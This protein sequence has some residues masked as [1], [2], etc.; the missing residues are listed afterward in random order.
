MSIQGSQA[1]AVGRAGSPDAAHIRYGFMHL[2][3]PVAR[4]SFSS[5][6]IPGP[7]LLQPPTDEW[8]PLPDALLEPDQEEW[9]DPRRKATAAVEEHPDPQR[10]HEAAPCSEPVGPIHAESAT[11]PGAPATHEATAPVSDSEKPLDALLVEALGRGLAVGPGAPHPDR[12]RATV[13]LLLELDPRRPA[14]WFAV[15]A[16][17]GSGLAAP[18]WP[19]PLP[20]AGECREWQALGQLTMMVRDRRGEV[21]AYLAAHHADSVEALGRP[22]AGVLAL[23]VLELALDEDPPSAQLLL[24]GLRTP[25]LD[26]RKLWTLVLEGCT[27]LIAES[28]ARTAHGLGETLLA[29]HP[30]ALVP[31]LEVQ[32][33]LMLSRVD[34]MQRRWNHALGHLA[35]L[36]PSST[37]A[38]EGAA[39]LWERTLVAARLVKVREVTPAR[40]DRATVVR[41]RLEAFRSDLAAVVTVQPAHA[42]ANYLLAC[43]ALAEGHSVVARERFGIALEGLEAE[44]SDS[45]LASRCRLWHGLLE[46][47]SGEAAACSSA[48]CDVMQAIRSGVRIPSRELE[49][50]LESLLALDAPE[51]GELLETLATGDR[52]REVSD[53]L[54]AEGLRAHPQLLGRA[55]QLS[56]RVNPSRRLAFLGAAL[57]LAASHAAEDDV[58]QLLERVDDDLAAHG[59]WHEWADIL[60]NAPQLRAVIDRDGT[61]VDL[62]ILNALIR[63]GPAQRKEQF[64]QVVC[65]LASKRRRDLDLAGL[66]EELADVED[67]DVVAELRAF[68]EQV[69]GVNPVL[70]PTSAGEPPRRP[71]GEKVRVLFVGGSEREEHA[72]RGARDILANRGLSEWVS[73]SWRH[74]GWGSNWAGKAQE[75]ESRFHDN[76]VL[77]LMP[78]VRTNFGRRIRRSAGEHGLRWFACTGHGPHSMANAIEAAAST[79]AHRAG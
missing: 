74:P 50:A 67:Q 29:R 39:V 17:H 77:V 31:D 33:V 42:E 76:D 48:A 35:D 3:E 15:G 9:E 34:R 8:I 22:Q 7:H 6:G 12:I 52:G 54:L 68:W 58:E 45:D 14:T 2:P 78:L 44:E 41:E 71:Q 36:D 70:P 10:G 28:D 25:G 1:A 13:D 21:V 73:V 49:G 62:C 75:A 61:W 11:A 27:R 18:G 26:A 65:R 46:L 63:G 47:E 59:G 37:P 30:G 38:N 66:F 19:G 40:P 32:T 64:E 55:T 53:Q 56:R 60:T 24:E 72:A 57:E 23:E 69:R 5:C 20:P 51:A 43:L 4:E 16:L 79:V